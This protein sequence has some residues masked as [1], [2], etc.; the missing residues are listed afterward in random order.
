MKLR[1]T[2]ALGSCQRPGC[3][4]QGRLRSQHAARRKLRMIYLCTECLENLRADQIYD[5]FRRFAENSNDAIGEL[6]RRHSLS[7]RLK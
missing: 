4:N 1:H 3:L 7:E 2:A 5:L 6:K